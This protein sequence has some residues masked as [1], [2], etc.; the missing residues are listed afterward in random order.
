MK[1]IITIFLVVFCINANAQVCFSSYTNYPTEGSSFCLTSADFNNDGKKDLV[2][3]NNDSLSLFINNGAGGFGIAVNFMVGSGEITAVL[4]ADFNADG[5]VDVVVGRQGISPMGIDSVAVLLGTGSGSF[6]TPT[7][8]PVGAGPNGMASADFNGDSIIDL[9][10]GNLNT[11]DVSI[12]LGNGVGGFSATTSFTA[13]TS[14]VRD[15]TAADFNVD[16]KIDIATANNGTSSVSIL[17]GDGT[18]NFGTPTSFTVGSGPYSIVNADFNEDTK[19]DLAITDESVHSVS[20]LLGNGTG[21]FGKASNFQVGSYP[22]DIYSGDFNNDG[23]IDLVTANDGLN[24][25]SMLLGTGTGSFGAASNFSAGKAPTCV[26]AEDFNADGMLDM[27]VTNQLSNNVTAILSCTPTSTCIVSVSFT[28]YQDTIPSTWDITPQY[29]S[30]VTNATWNW[31][32]GTSS[33][34]LYPSHIYST[35]NFYTQCV[36]VYNNCGDSATTCKLDSVFRMSQANANM[37]YINVLPSSTAGINQQKNQNAEAKIY[38]NPAASIL[39]LSINGNQNLEYDVQITD[40][41]GNEITKQTILPNSQ[42]TVDISS[43]SNGVYF[44]RIGNS[45]QKFIVQH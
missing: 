5:N 31:G 6:G 20:I 7:D 11:H 1:K 30:Q 21:S 42:T 45:T 26:I 8:F 39:Q 33:T 22:W 2:T 32:D 3:V 18:G 36:T 23:H 34:G 35:P 12:L 24:N 10:V 44:I 37:V 4:S 43:F 9:A 28:L 13:S 40:V 29:S 25:V 27:A 38:P 17:L 15:V 41:L 19:I 16:G 14:W